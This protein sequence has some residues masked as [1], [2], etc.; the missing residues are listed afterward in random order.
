MEIKELQKIYA[1]HPGVEALTGITADG[2]KEKVVIGGLTASSAAVAIAGYMQRNEKQTLFIVMNDVEEAGY[3]YHD[4][5]Q[6][7]GEQRVLFFPSSFRRALKY[8]HE[9]DA[10]RILRTEVMSRLASRSKRNGTV[11][12]TH[13]EAIAEKV[14]S[15]EKM[16]SN[17]M[18]LAVGGMLSREEAEKK[19][20]KLG[21]KEVQYVY[22]PGE[23]AQR[24]SLLDIFSCNEWSNPQFSCKILTPFFL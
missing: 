24:G 10:N 18:T 2:N 15:Q 5:V 1:T 22:E 3:F 17:T 7:C 23:Y 6:I 8:G 9:D 12:V 4:L 11:V 19:L 14:V 13:P 21:F 16:E 20:N